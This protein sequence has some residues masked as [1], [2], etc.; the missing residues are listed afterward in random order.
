MPRR[1]G[2][3]DEGNKVTFEFDETREFTRALRVRDRRA[4]NRSRT[5]MGRAIAS[6][7]AEGPKKDVMKSAEMNDVNVLGVEEE[8][9]DL[10]ELAETMSDD[11]GQGVGEESLLDAFGSTAGSVGVGRGL[12]TVLSMLKHT[13]EIAGKHAGKEEL[14][15]RAKDERTYEDYEAL[16]LDKVVKVGSTANE[17]DRELANREIKLEYRDDHG[18]LLT[19]KE[20]FRN[21][22]YQ[23]H[24]YGSSKNNEERRL[25]QIDRERAEAAAVARRGDMLGALR[26]TQKA[27]GKAFVVQKT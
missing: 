21:L 5:G 15:G 19:R 23:F 11:G 3:E 13:G 7:G 26:A 1:D 20:A 6:V 22:C 4:S 24:G 8:H 14:R 10:E 18:R 27:T 16:N 2:K 9:V 12:S 17:K 25:K